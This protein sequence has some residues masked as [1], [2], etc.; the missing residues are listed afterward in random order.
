MLDIVG[1]SY[2][3]KNL[4]LLNPYGRMVSLAFLESAKA[5]LNMAHLVFK[6]LSWYGVTLRG[7]TTKQKAQLT[8]EMKQ[9][10]WD[11]LE[12]RKVVPVID[13][14]FDLKDAEKAH[15]KMQQNLNLG[16]ILLKA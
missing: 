4:K 11:W 13:D 15:K 9:Y 2:F 10:C 8:Q 6:Q 14:E 12:N 3:Q 1:G 16:K 5:E 7:R